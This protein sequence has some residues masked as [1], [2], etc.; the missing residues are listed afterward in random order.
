MPIH[1]QSY[2]RYIG[3]REAP[4]RT[5]LVIASAGIR[6]I[7][8]KKKFLGLLL[9]AWLP[10]LVRTIQMYI[11]ANFPQASILTP[12]AET[13]REF[14]DQQGVFVFFITL[15][16]G[17]GLIANDKRANALQIYLS[18]PMT[19]A[20]YVAGKVAILATFLFMVTWVPAILLV[21][22][23]IVFSGSTEFIRANLFVIP[24]I[25]VFSIVE[26]AVASITM[27]ALSSASKSGRFVAI[28]YT[29]VMYFSEAIYG[30]LF[31]VTRGT[32]V[33]WISL[34]GNLRQV[35]DLIFRLDPR[36]DTHPLI[37]L[38]ALG[39][40]VGVSVVVLERSVRGVEVVT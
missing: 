4:G 6:T 33:S 37:T 23:Q 39:V 25:T 18:K 35:G 5:W 14:L 31:M 9:V 34:P 13:F 16:V 36:Y 38:L 3:R 15:F 8:A 22:A 11:S 17:A 1:D 32:S 10:F 21:V 26:V 20:E 19:R 24:A 28:L 27:A 40:L 30:V 7:I 2:R 12:T 29:G